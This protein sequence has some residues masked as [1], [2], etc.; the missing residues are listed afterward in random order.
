MKRW[1]D[2]PHPPLPVVIPRV[3][4]L[5]D[6]CR[7]S[8]IVAQPWAADPAKL[9]LDYEGNIYGAVNI[10]NFADRVDHAYGRQITEYPTTAR[11]WVDKDQV[12]EIG[13]WDPEKGEVILHPGEEIRGLVCTWLEVLTVSEVDLRSSRVGGGWKQ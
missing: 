2:I 9:M 1:K 5:P 4:C 13:V 6:I 8:G 12:I 3:G 11:C 7:G 10:K